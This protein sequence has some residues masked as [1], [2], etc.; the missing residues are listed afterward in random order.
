M[1]FIDQLKEALIFLCYWIFLAKNTVYILLNKVFFI[2]S[3]SKFLKILF[4][5]DYMCIAKFMSS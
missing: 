5:S 4:G 1:K 2:A 3:K